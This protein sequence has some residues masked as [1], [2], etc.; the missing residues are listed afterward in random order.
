MVPEDLKWSIQAK[1]TKQVDN[2]NKCQKP[3]FGIECPR[4]QFTEDIKI[5]LSIDIQAL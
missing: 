4:T 3:Q 1:D 5:C 2:A